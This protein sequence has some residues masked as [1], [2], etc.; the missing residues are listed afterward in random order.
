M[1]CVVDGLSRSLVS[2]VSALYGQGF[3][4]ATGF[5]AAVGPIRARRCAA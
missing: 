4:A 5:G 3:P 1:R 2:A